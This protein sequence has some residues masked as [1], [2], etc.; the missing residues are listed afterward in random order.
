MQ[1]VTHRHCP[2]PIK[3]NTNIDPLLISRT[4]KGDETFGLVKTR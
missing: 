1:A 3:V 2:K 4:R